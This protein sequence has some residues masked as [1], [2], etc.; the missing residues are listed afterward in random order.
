MHDLYDRT[1]AAALEAAGRLLA[2]R[3]SSGHWTGELAPNAVATSAA[4]CALALLDQQ[5]GITD[6]GAANIVRAGL[7]WLSRNANCDGG[8]GDTPLSLSNISATT[9]AWAAFG[10]A[11]GADDDYASTVTGAENWLAADIGGLSPGKLAQA[12]SARYG[13]DRTFAVPILTACALAGRFGQGAQAWKLV[14]Q[15]PFE[16]AACPP[17]WFAALRFPVVSCALPALIAVGQVRDHRLATRNPITRMARRLT[18]ARTMG[19]LHRIQPSSGGFLE[20]V[21]LTAFVTMSL[22]GSG[23]VDNAV[24]RRGAAFLMASARADGAWPVD[25]NLATWLTTLSVNALAGTAGPDALEV[26][27]DAESRAR[28]VSWL[29]E[30]QHKT[31]HPCTR[32]PPGGW[33]RTDLAGGIPDADNTAG[34]LLA[35]HNLGDR[36]QEVLLAVER[37]IEWLLN[38]QNPDGGIPTFCRGWT[39]L[40]FDRSGSD[41]TAHA[42]RAWLVWRDELPE[43]IQPRIEQATDRALQ[44]LGRTMREDGTWAPLWFGN[45]WNPARENPVYGTARV[46][47]AMRLALLSGHKQ[48]G[49]RLSEGTRALAKL[50]RDDGGWGGD[51]TSGPGSIE[52]TALATEAL[53]AVRSTPDVHP[54]MRNPGAS[55]DRGVGWLISHCGQAGDLPASPIGFDFTSLWYYERLY[56]V[57]FAAAALLEARAALARCGIAGADP[58]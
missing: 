35:L 51:P 39:N 17:C 34:A 18:R 13:K 40:P 30:Q 47:K 10:A 43:R 7:D 19:I 6:G 46:V 56:P 42:L 26:W 50:Q 54:F 31:E 38:L 49:I 23:H 52:E 24:V 15:L 48:A 57:I 37:A 9:L 1:Q 28:I 5:G 25:S 4:I 44:H 11:P 14:P 22:V 58:S 8:W 41:L 21:P 53:A 55:L 29:L 33:A 32:A 45:Q 3:D 12:I 36:S 16:L 20:A 2:M 27:L